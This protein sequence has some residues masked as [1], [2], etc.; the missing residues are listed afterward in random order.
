MHCHVAVGGPVAGVGEAHLRAGGLCTHKDAGQ[1]VRPWLYRRVLASLFPAESQG[2]LYIFK[3]EER[4]L[5][6]QARRMPTF[7]F[8]SCLLVAS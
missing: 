5:L 6:S 2:R 1:P 4:T 8:L 7:E 3:Y